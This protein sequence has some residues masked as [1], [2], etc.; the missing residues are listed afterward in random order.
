MAKIIL[1][2]RCKQNEQQAKA[3]KKIHLTQTFG[4]FTAF[5][6]MTFIAT[7]FIGT[8]RKKKAEKIN[9]F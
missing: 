3:Q 6:F 5:C 2:A 4:Y 9:K 7:N 1:V 8:K